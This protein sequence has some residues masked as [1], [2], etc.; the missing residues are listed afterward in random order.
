MAHDRVLDFLFDFL[1]GWVDLKGISMNPQ[2]LKKIHLL[3][4]VITAFGLSCGLFVIFKMN[5]TGV[6]E[7]T[8]KILT[9]VTAIL[10]LAAVADLLDGAVAR[11]IKAESDFGGLFD[12]LADAISFGVAPSVIILKSLSAA[13]GTQ[14][15]FLATVSAIIFSLCGV[16]RLVRFNVL[17]IEAKN[18]SELAV[19]HKKHF[20]GLPIPASAAAAVSLNLFLFASEIPFMNNL[21]ATFQT[22]ILSIMMLLLGY[23]MVSRWKF[24]SIKSLEIRV[25]SFSVVFLTGF[26]AVIILYGI[27]NY[28]SL[29]LVILSW[30][31][32]GVALVLAIVRII[33]GRKSKTLEDFEPEPDDL[34][35]D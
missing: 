15:S 6:G 18:N 11:V 10:L 32:I 29:V 9:A 27:L 19:A 31:Y 13:Q 4:N 25:S 26:A 34:E 22:W 23:C 5:M 17:A 7:V 35:E 33:A 21:S 8:P 2:K 14:L 20:T 1:I 28:S 12:S 30:G 24:P 3:P 16:L